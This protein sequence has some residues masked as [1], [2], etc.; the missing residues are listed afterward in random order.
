MQVGS[1]EGQSS[2]SESD[3]QRVYIQ[4]LEIVLHSTKKEEIV[5]HTLA[6]K[7]HRKV[8]GSH[9]NKQ[10]EIFLEKKKS[11]ESMNHLTIFYILEII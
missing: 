5:L 1:L 6:I 10:T 4:T 11:A 9:K 3:R 2:D 7:N 8:Y